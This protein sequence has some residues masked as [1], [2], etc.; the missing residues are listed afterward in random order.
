MDKVFDICIIGSGPA[1]AFAARNLADSGKDVVVVEAGGKDVDSEPRNIIDIENSNIPGTPDFGFSQQIGGA[2]NLWAGGL[3]ELDEVDFIKREEFEF[4]GWIFKKDEL[5][6]YY[7]QVNEYI[8]V[9][10]DKVSRDILGN[11]N[12]HLRD[13]NVLDTPF[14]TGI[15]L[16]GVSKLT[17]LDM[18]VATKLIVDSTNQSIKSVEIYDKKSNNTKKI[19][20]K[21]YIVAS[22]T[23]TNIRLLLHSFN[24]IKNNIP[25]L[26]DNIGRYFSTHPKGDIGTLKL[27]K[28]LEYTHA[29]VSI[30]KN[31]S[32]THWHQFGLSKK[33]LLQNNL[34]NHCLRFSSPF[35]QRATRIFDMMKKVIGTIPMFRDGLVANILVKIGVYIFRFID[36]SRFFSFNSKKLV[37]RAFFDQKSSPLNRVTISDKTS[38]EGLPLAKVDYVFDESDWEKVEKFIDIFSQELQRLEIGELEYKRPNK[39]K[40]TGMHSHFI[41]GTRMGKSSENSVVDENLKVH[42]FDNLYVSGP[43]TF[44]SFGYANPLYSIAAISLKLADYIKDKDG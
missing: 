12:I 25:K 36:H 28:P 33:F 10:P 30:E 1:G 8:K 17:L 2:S 43:S 11:S 26:F 4:N 39:D 5:T 13:I 14:A 20:A 22:G 38:K 37:V 3:V 32:F 7:N 19:Y 35:H 6:K 21:K 15:L 9:K 40:F 18:S 29:L 24:C 27:Y 44:P 42:G 31:N 41:G 16:E 23:L 34:L